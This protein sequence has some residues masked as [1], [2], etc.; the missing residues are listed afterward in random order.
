MSPVIGMQYFFF[1]TLNYSYKTDCQCESQT[2]DI[3][4]QVPTFLRYLAY[5]YFVFQYLLCI[6]IAYLGEGNGTPLQ[7]SCLENPVDRRAW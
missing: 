7:Y 6:F 2:L 3:T 5:F 4:D 1:L